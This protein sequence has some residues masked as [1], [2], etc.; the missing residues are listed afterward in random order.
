VKP[1]VCQLCGARINVDLWRSRRPG[2]MVAFAFCRDD[3]PTIPA[4]GVAKREVLAVIEATVAWRAVN[5][6]L[7]RPTVH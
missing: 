4:I 2:T 6:Q 3:C 7:A 1:T 5:G